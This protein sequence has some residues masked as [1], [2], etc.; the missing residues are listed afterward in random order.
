MTGS[1]TLK[2]GPS[3]KNMWSLRTGISS[4]SWQWSLK[5]GFTVYAVGWPSSKT[6]TADQWVVRSNP[7]WDILYLIAHKLLNPV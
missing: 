4:C 7:D 5:I 1:V 2:L 3:A 6:V